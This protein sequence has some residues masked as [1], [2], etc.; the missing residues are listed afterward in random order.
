MRK[1]KYFRYLEKY[2]GT[3]C[4]RAELNPD[5]NDFPRDSNGK[6]FDSFED[7]YIPCRRGMIK[8]T[9]ENDLLVIYFL[10]AIGMKN[11]VAKEFDEQGIWY[12]DESFGAD[13]VLFF[14]ET[15]IEKVAKII[16]PKTNGKK[17]KPFSP[18][19]IKKEKSDFKI[20]EQELKKYELLISDLDDLEHIEKMQ[21][22]RKT[23]KDF[24]QM[25]LQEKGSDFNITKQRK[26]TG[27]KP[28]E[29]YYKIGLWDKYLDFVQGEMNKR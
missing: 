12:R 27:L 23:A 15:D 8:H 21:F 20:P 16:V 22:L 2:V 18:K 19:A 7:L 6:I 17:T 14:H 25:I 26:E 1:S 9:Y 11:N 4:V 13:G 24:E 5:T 28:K 10:N 29:F 3:Y